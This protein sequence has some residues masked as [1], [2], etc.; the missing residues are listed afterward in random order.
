MPIITI[1]PEN[2]TKTCTTNLIGL[3]ISKFISTFSGEFDYITMPYTHKKYCYEL[4]K[5]KY[6]ILSCFII[7]QFLI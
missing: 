6:A 3:N 2:P 7:H 1:E 5:S 4:Y